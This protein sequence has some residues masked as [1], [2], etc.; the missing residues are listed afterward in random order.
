MKKEIKEKAFVSNREVAVERVGQNQLFL[1]FGMFDATDVGKEK[2]KVAVSNSG[3][4][5]LIDVD[6]PKWRKKNPG[7]I[8]PFRYKITARALVELAY[9]AYQEQKKE[10]EKNS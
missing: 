4:S 2:L 10:Y 1:R 5:L 8:S 9:E 3:G 6:D 7:E